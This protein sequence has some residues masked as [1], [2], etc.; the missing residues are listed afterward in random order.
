[1]NNTN[2]FGVPIEKFSDEDIL[3]FADKPNGRPD[4]KLGYRTQEELFE[5][6]LDKV[7]AT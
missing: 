5:I 7:Y 3:V 2:C 1:M 4:R 6:L